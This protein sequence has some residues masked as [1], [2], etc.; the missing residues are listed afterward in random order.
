MQHLGNVA[1]LSVG[2]MAAN[3]SPEHL[4]KTINVL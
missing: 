2:Y 4:E 1:V 3:L